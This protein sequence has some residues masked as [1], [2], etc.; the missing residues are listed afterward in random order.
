MSDTCTRIVTIL[1][2]QSGIPADKITGESLLGYDR[3][4]VADA[5]PLELDSLDL[6]ETALI[7]EEEF[8]IEIPDDHVDSPALGTVAGL[9]AYVEGKRMTRQSK[10][11]ITILDGPYLGDIEGLIDHTK[12]V[13][14]QATG[15]TSAMLSDDVR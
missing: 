14:N 8:G 6:I 3:A 10:E 4:R 13:I 11:P 5:T 15:I 9:V 2:K 12:E 1:A 7:V